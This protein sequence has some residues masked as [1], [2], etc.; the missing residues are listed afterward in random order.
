MIP[1][2]MGPMVGLAFGMLGILFWIVGLLALDWFAERLGV[3]D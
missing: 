1:E 2:G 3:E